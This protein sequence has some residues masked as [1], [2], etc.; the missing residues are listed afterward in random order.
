M[1]KLAFYK[2]KV[3]SSLTDSADILQA[4]LVKLCQTNESLPI[5]HT[6]PHMYCCL[7]IDLELHRVVHFHQS[8]YFELLYITDFELLFTGPVFVEFPIDT[9]Y[10]YELVRREI[11]MKEKGPVNFVQRIINW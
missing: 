7:H 8:R 4:F 1:T 10:P 11:G 2:L 9:L 5:L 6:V 3:K